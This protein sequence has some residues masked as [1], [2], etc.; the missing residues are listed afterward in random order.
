MPAATSSTAST[1]V[2]HA[3]RRPRIESKLMASGSRPAC[4]R[5]VSSRLENVAGA[6]DRVDQFRIALAVDDPPQPADVDLDEVREGIELVVPNVLGDLLAPHDPA[7]V[8]SQELQQTVL[9]GR[10]QQLVPAARNAV[11]ARVEA[12]VA[13]LDH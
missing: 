4:C 5:R 3:V 1:A 6:T 10:E 13:D 8:H 7:G 12:Q 9:L 2:Y 11:R